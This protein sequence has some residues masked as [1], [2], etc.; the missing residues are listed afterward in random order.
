MSKIYTF[1]EEKDPEKI[2]EFAAACSI[3]GADAIA[4]FSHPGAVSEDMTWLR[5]IMGD[6][7]SVTLVTVL[8]GVAFVRDFVARIP[9]ID[10]ELLTK[11]MNGRPPFKSSLLRRVFIPMGSVR[12]PNAETGRSPMPFPL[13]YGASLG[14]GAMGQAFPGMQ[15]IL[16]KGDSVPDPEEAAIFKAHRENMAKQGIK[17]FSKSAVEDYIKDSIVLA[18]DDFGKAMAADFKADLIE[19]ALNRMPPAT[20]LPAPVSRNFVLPETLNEDEKALAEKML[21]G[22]GLKA[23]ANFANI[24][25]QRITKTHLPSIREK[26]RAESLDFDEL[27][28]AAREKAGEGSDTQEGGANE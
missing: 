8:P 17:E 19:G 27:W 4:I 3:L 23:S 28:K 12:L 2:R 22:R 26:F 14:D 10:R 9:D 1:I 5:D 6:L 11:G 7:W 25:W 13:T 24:P 21:E 16:I 15:H 18:H 20:T